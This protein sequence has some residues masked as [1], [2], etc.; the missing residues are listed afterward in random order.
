MAAMMVGRKYRKLLSK[1]IFKIA[2]KS[3]LPPNFMEMMH[4]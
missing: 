3:Q 1:N 4:I 2:V